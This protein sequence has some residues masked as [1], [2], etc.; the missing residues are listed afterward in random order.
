MV[1]TM[2]D[3]LLE[4]EIS[5]A[6]CD[7]IYIEQAAAEIEVA[8]AIVDAYLKQAIMLEYAD[9]GS[10]YLEAEGKGFFKTIWEGIV[11]LATSIWSAITGLVDKIKTYFAN[12]KLARAKKVVENANASNNTEEKDR[13]IAAIKSEVS[14]VSVR[15]LKTGV[16]LTKKAIDDYVTTLEGMHDFFVSQVELAAREKIGDDKGIQKKFNTL[17]QKSEEISEKIKNYTT[18][19]GSDRDTSE[20]SSDEWQTVADFFEKDLDSIAVDIKDILSRLKESEKIIKVIKSD[21]QKFLEAKKMKN[22]GKQAKEDERVA[23]HNSNLVRDTE[24]ELA[25]TI[26][27]TIKNYNAAIVNSLRD[28]D[29][30]LNAIADATSKGIIKANM[31]E[32]NKQMSDAY[33]TENRRRQATKQAFS[34]YGSTGDDFGWVKSSTTPGVTTETDSKTGEKKTVIHDFD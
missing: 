11:S 30:I 32:A 26:S 15:K 19:L 13:I 33:N 20:H 18:K 25:R 23:A 8:S 24:P 29:K 6:S 22:A 5:R 31:K 1:I 21:S 28:Y 27:S 2:S 7:D 10:V 34:D 9:D 16:T 17:K 4:Q 14:F 3:Y 12:K